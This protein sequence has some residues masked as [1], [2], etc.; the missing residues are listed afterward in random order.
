M[1]LRSPGVNRYFRNYLV[2]Q[3]IEQTQRSTG[4][5][6]LVSAAR[7][8][9]RQLRQKLQT[10]G[11]EVT[12]ESFSAALNEVMHE[13]V[14]GYPGLLDDGPDSTFQEQAKQRFMTMVRERDTLPISPYD[15]LWQS[16][17]TMREAGHGL[18]FARG[19][20]IELFAHQGVPMGAHQYRGE[21]FQLLGPD[22]EGVLREVGAAMSLEDKAGLTELASRMTMEEYRSVR[23]HVL[24]AGESNFMSATAVERSAAVLDELRDQGVSY[25]VQKDLRP[26]QIKARISGT[27]MDI[28]LTDTAR[29]EHYAGARIYEDGVLTYYSTTLI[30]QAQ[31]KKGASMPY[32]PTAAQAVDLLR[33]AQGKEAKRWDEPQTSIGAVGTHRRG[34]GEMPNAYTPKNS[35][36]SATYVA[37][38]LRGP[39]GSAL[40][41]AEGREVSGHKVLIRRSAENRSLPVAYLGDTEEATAAQRAE[42]ALQSHVESAR[43]NFTEALA[44]D[45]LVEQYQDNAEAAEAG[46]FV[47]EFSG[48][49]EVAAIQRS[50]WDVLRG[51]QDTLLRP[52]VDAQAYRDEVERIDEMGLGAESASFLYQS[53][54]G[55]M[56]YTG[57][58]SPIE[59]VRAH[60]GD[61]A[62]Q[63]IGTFEPRM[64]GELDQQRRRFNPARVAQ[65]MTSEKGYWGNREDLISALRSSTIA[66]EELDGEGF[67]VESLK[68]QLITF[69]AASAK[70]RDEVEDPFVASMM[71]TVSQTLSRA[72]ATP[73]DVRIDDH[74]VIEYTATRTVG[75]RDAS[76]EQFTGHVGQVF[77]RGE[78]GEVVTD[79]AASENY[80]M[81]PG[82]LA[83]ISAQRPGEEKSVEERT[84]L[85]GFEQVLGERI[86]HRV[87]TDVLSG[88]SVVGD[89]TTLNGVYRGLYD[90]RHE[91]DFI[92][93]AQEQGMSAAQVD[94]VLSTEARRVRYDNEIAQGSTL[95]AEWLASRSDQDMTNDVYDSAWVRTGGRNMAIMTEESDGYFDPVMTNGATGQGTVRFLVESA[96]V[97]EDGSIVK[98]AEDDAAP[99]RKL[100]EMAATQFDPYDRQQMTTSN[101]MHASGVSSNTR[102]AMMT[103][104]GWT[105]DD[106]VVVSAGFAGQNQVRGKDG[107]LRDL[108]PGDKVSDFHGN[109]GVIS[110]V[111]DPDMDPAEAA[112]QGLS[113]PVEIFRD[114]PGLDVVMSP[115]S[116]ASRFN[117]GTARELMDNPQDLTLGD[118]QISGGVGEMNLIIT[119]KDV[120]SG[121]KVYDQPGDGRRA[122]AQLAWALGSHDA[123]EVMAEFYGSNSAAAANFREMAVSMGLDMADDGTLQVGQR[124]DSQRHVFEMEELVRRDPGPG[125]QLGRVSQPA[126]AARFAAEIDD[127][128]GIMELPFP[129]KMPTGEMT[130]EVE[131]KPGVYALPVLSAHLRSG[132]DLDNGVSTAHDYTRQYLQIFKSS[133]TYR[134]AQERL[135]K[136][137]PSN[138]NRGLAGEKAKVNESLAKAQGAF[139]SITSDLSRRKFSGKTNMFKE[140]LMSA[141]QPNSAT[142]VWTADPRLEVDQVGMG[143]AMAQSLGVEDDDY[144]MLW[145]DPVLRDAGVRY[146]RVAVDERLTG[147]AINPVM[148]KSFDGDFDGDSVGVVALQSDSAKAEA[149]DKLSVE[150]NLLDEGLVDDL[151]R[152]PLNIQDSLDV[153]VAQ[154]QDPELA[155]RFEE[156]TQRANDIDH[157]WKAGELGDDAR[158][159]ANREVVAGLSDYYHQALE[160][161][162]GNAVLRFDGA[163]SHLSSVVE[164]CVDTGAK[165]S[166]AK[167]S[168]YAEYFGARISFAEGEE[169]ASQ[170]LSVDSVEENTLH[171]REQEQGSMRAVAVK[172]FGTGIAGAF[173]QRGVKSLRNEQLK[174]VLELTYPVTQSVLQSKHD[175]TEADMKYEAMLG[176]AKALWQGCELARAEDGTFEAVRD[177][178]GEPVTADAQTWK[179]QFKEFYEDPKGLNIKGL[180]PENIDKVA[181]AL[182]DPETGKILSV[183]EPDL[184]VES[185]KDTALMDRLAYGG[186]FDMLHEAAQSG[187]N[188]FDG[189]KNGH[190]APRTVRQAQSLSAELDQAR[191][192]DLPATAEELVE[193]V[194][195][196]PSQVPADV[197]PSTDE[198]SKART[199]TKR[200]PQAVG[201]RAP[202]TTRP[203]IEPVSSYS[204]TEVED[205]GPDFG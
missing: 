122:S 175:P 18:R 83:R 136:D 156:L 192:L 38:D 184:L 92:T 110:L 155:A 102:T 189:E 19:T 131:D 159:D 115:F 66:A 187:Q 74:G 116:A 160:S 181:A 152:H 6:M 167:V 64:V 126:M 20:D 55:D 81:V 130:P 99:L 169:P 140:S 144:V 124:E 141:D 75:V 166:P 91:P 61:A 148:D 123:T 35:G 10:S 26:G 93:R 58:M 59:K 198:R 194:E 177:T 72:G 165:G 12:R 139:E 67:Q 132:Q 63:M 180:N 195:Q 178:K 73:Q 120:E 146:M 157:D 204:A 41:D 78:Y 196:A 45:Q 125:Q 171:T 7:E 4:R 52:G 88:R 173:S 190:F 39:D 16:R 143:A 87:A 89:P 47:P 103:F 13:N 96:Q 25:E 48:N 147:A 57:A 186:D 43:E 128:G 82:Y 150:A 53:T 46:E 193:Q 80:M 133:V 200:S 33:V 170:R 129:L 42:T 188:L 142:A 1:Q 119:H 112:E 95:H 44:M 54:L 205:S 65:Y 71:D 14:E 31:G 36:A 176:P 164:A 49:E 201:V 168:N 117:G 60:A 37:G 24:S 11:D 114:N 8:L 162:Y 50:Y 163:E 17:A 174:A 104:G 77:G 27:K 161:E 107:E 76:A 90:N 69:D 21:D 51:A 191:R 137:A 56:A 9:N 106:P 98:G 62:D 70:G 32:T 149:M 30:D 94:A 84:R 199:A 138:K 158:L 153:K 118:R 134:D 40:R 108:I 183:E 197:L 101:M 34:N 127:R 203:V 22:E 3:V 29:D 15:T 85:R 151:G 100:D 185:G 179:A 2:H 135:A 79:F 68:D 105:F 182:T 109:K 145:R 172:S 28:R 121:T 23:S 86:Q 111:V 97:A 5:P 154:H 202:R 113:K